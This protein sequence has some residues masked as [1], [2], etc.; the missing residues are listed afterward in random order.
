MLKLRY[1]TCV[2]FPALYI[3]KRLYDLFHIPFVDTIFK[4]RLRNKIYTQEC[5]YVGRIKS[6]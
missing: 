4:M 2:H 5:I 1:R 6:I 3:E